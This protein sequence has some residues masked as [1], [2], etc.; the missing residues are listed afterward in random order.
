VLPDECLRRIWAVTTHPFPG[1][2]VVHLLADSADLIEAV[3][4]L[5]WLEWD[6]VLNPSTL[7]GGIREAGRSGLPITWVGSDQSGALG[8]VGL[9]RQKMRE[10][11]PPP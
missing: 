6:M 11:P 3:T 1:S 10:K 9:A 5:R 2:A 7:T 8:A 4:D